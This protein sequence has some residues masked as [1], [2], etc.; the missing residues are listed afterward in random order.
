MDTPTHALIGRVIARR[1]CDKADNATVNLVTAMGVLPDIDTF[2]GGDDLSYIQDHRGITHSV[3]GVGLMGLVV[4]AVAGRLGVPG[5]FARR[6]GFAVVGMLLHILFDILTSYGTQVLAP[7]TDNRFTIDV[8][9]II[10][11]YLTGILIVALLTGW[12]YRTRAYSIG[13]AVF[14][15]YVG[16]NVALLGYGA[17]QAENWANREDIHVDRVGVMPMPFSP[18]HRRAFIESGDTTY[19]ITVPAM[20]IAGSTVETYPRALRRP[21]LNF[22]WD[23]EAGSTY[24][25]FSR[26]P[27][28]TSEV[29]AETI[30]EDLTYKIRDSGLGWLGQL[31]LDTATESTPEFLDRRIFYLTVNTETRTVSFAR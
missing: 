23:T 29:G 22:V 27:V 5:A 7:L 16:L 17:V 11:P 3:F 30:I 6:Y 24:R 19:W 1:F 4:A 18:L 13:F 15:G 21:H 28:V 31:A 25:W 9:F 12:L 26:Y 20:G 14:V 2:F 8:L 10:D